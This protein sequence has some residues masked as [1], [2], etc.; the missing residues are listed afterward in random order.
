MLKRRKYI[1]PKPHT[2]VDVYPHIPYTPFLNLVF[3]AFPYSR[4]CK[5]V[6]LQALIP[7]IFIFPSHSQI[8]HLHRMVCLLHLRIFPEY[9]SFLFSGEISYTC[10]FFSL[11]LH[12][13]TAACIAPHFHIAKVS[14]AKNT[15]PDYVVSVP[16]LAWQAGSQYQ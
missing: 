3:F 4:F 9:R 16:R 15:A 7:L 2:H 11:Y 12:C 14:L 10:I 5:Y 8:F 6:V 1:T 13:L